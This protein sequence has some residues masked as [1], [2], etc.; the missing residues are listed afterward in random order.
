MQKSWGGNELDIPKD[1]I[2]VFKEQKQCSYV[3]GCDGESCV[4]QAAG[5]KF[6]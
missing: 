2:D 1:E 5:D 3:Q 4:R 6:I